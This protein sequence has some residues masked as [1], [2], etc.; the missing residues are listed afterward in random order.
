MPDGGFEVLELVLHS[1]PVIK[2]VLLSLVLFSVI[3]WAVIAE[4]HRSYRRARRLDAHVARAL[5]QAVHLSDLR[6]V[7]DS[8]PHSPFAGLLRATAAE[9]RSQAGAGPPEAATAARDLESALRQAIL[10]EVAHLER[11]LGF[12]ATTGS[13][14]PFIGLFGTVW[15]IMHAFRNIGSMGSANLATVA[16]G[17]SEALVATAAGLAAAIPAVMAYNYF[18]GRVRGMRNGLEGFALEVLRWTGRAARTGV[19]RTREGR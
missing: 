12:L 8:R 1:G 15:G 17:I 14:S 16:P 6:A 13:V 7:V 19:A 18:V 10:E 11:R 5:R 2:A 9:L 4:R 3:S